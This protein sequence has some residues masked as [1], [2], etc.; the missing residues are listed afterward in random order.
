MEWEPAEPVAWDAA[1]PV[2][3]E[4]APGVG[5]NSQ[6]REQGQHRGEG[7]GFTRG[8]FFFFPKRERDLIG[9]FGNIWF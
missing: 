1:E 5:D 7:K 4:A 3:W 6:R 2:A 8:G 9:C